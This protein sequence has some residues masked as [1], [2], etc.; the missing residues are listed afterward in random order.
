MDITTTPQ[1]WNGSL[2]V[3]L[4]WIPEEAV[5]YEIMTAPETAV[6]F[7]KRSSIRAILFYNVQ[8]NISIEAVSCSQNSERVTTTVSLHYGEGLLNIVSLI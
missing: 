4:E 1:F 8:Y 2:S 7:L 6:D 3:I 5:T